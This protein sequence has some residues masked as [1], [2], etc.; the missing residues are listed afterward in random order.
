MAVPDF[1]SIFR[2]LLT[3]LNDDQDHHVSDIRARL[4]ADFSLAEEDLQET[5]PSGRVTKFQNRVGWATTTS[6][7]RA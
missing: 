6:T 4:A 1:Q 5:I 7:G 2:P 3:V